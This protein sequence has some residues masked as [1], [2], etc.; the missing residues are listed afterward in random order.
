MEIGLPREHP[1]RSRRTGRPLC[2]LAGTL[3]L[4]AGCGSATQGGT[5]TGYGAPPATTPSPSSAAREIEVELD[6]YYFDPATLSLKQGEEVTLKLV[7]ES[8]APHTFTV[9]ALGV[10]VMVPAGATKTVTVKPERS[11]QFPLVC[12][13]HKDMGMQ[14]KVVVGP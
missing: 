7:N 4:A 3:L 5:A 14:G 11:G 2:L 13:Y 12:R 8:Q 6:S 9:G 1:R 10:D